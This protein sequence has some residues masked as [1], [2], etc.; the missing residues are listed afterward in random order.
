MARS[1]AHGRPWRVAIVADYTEERW[2]S[3]DRVAETLTE[4][5]A[6]NHA[7]EVTPVLVRPPFHYRFTA[8]ARTDGRALFVNADRLV[9]RFLDYP[10]AMRGLRNDF[11]LFHI[12]DHSY[13][14]LVHTLPA[15][16]TCVTCHD[17]DTFRCLLEPEREP[18]S[19]P[20]R[21][22][23]RRILSGLGRAAMI[24]CDS[25]ATHD[26][27][28]H[29]GIAEAARTTVIHVGV[30][31]VFSPAANAS[32]DAETARMLG[33]IDGAVTELLHVG[34]P[35][36]RK[37]ID[38]LL[39]L[40]S[41]LRRLWPALRLVRVGGQFTAEQQKLADELGVAEAIA[42]LPRVSDAVLAAVYRRAAL[43]LMPSDAEGFG[44]P[45]LEGMACGTPVLASTIAALREVG[46][47]AAEYA[48]AGDIEAWTVAAKRLL[49]ERQDD[50]ISW[51]ARCHRARGR[52]TQFSW[53]E[54]A[55]RTVA[56]Y[57][58][59]AGADS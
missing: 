7:A 17:L 20:F 36:A 37:R 27:L 57:R 56:L 38:L 58:A 40:F 18:R 39:R 21:M 49:R 30:S 1:H 4:R 51:T 5:L 50:A 22:M 12:V 59:I 41:A 44:L 46:G 24:A 42:V 45:L 16:R 2:P 25:Q 52:A 9:N 19:A 33:P 11:D 55:A 31:A 23:T 10:A 43:V 34:T 13:A 54:S 28:L 53:D 26:E 6:A 47:N 48:L 8:P 3:M 15:D 14:H 35:V 32:A 29:W